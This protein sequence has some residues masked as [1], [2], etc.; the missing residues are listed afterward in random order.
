M[1][2]TDQPK[3][4]LLGSGPLNARGFSRCRA[5]KKDWGIEP[6]IWNVT[7]FSELREEAEAVEGGT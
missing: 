2:G 3:I 1:R 6:G 4:R 7:S 5:V